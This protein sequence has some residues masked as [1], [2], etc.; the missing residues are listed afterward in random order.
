M[1][2]T[3]RTGS[4]V[5]GLANTFQVLQGDWVQITPYGDFPHDA[6]IQRVDAEAG[7]QMV[8]SFNAEMA[9]EAGRFVGLP[10]YIGHPDLDRSCYRDGASYGRIKQ[11]QT[12]ND[13]LYGRVKWAN[14]GDELIRDGAYAYFS[15]CWDGELVGEVN[16][17]KII[18]PSQ[19]RSVGFTNTPNI[20]VM[21]LANEAGQ[22]RWDRT[23]ES[24]RREVVLALVNDKMIST[25]LDY[26]AAYIAVRRDNALLFSAMIKPP[27]PAKT[28]E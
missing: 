10:W 21:P 27:M 3:A 19:L 5:L 28:H 22:K 4:R 7:R 15:P 1:L 25:G 24:E 8:Q 2:M 23:T 13:G 14:A 16:G 26:T 20:P 12:R 6:G 17:K 11:L 18:R 9:N